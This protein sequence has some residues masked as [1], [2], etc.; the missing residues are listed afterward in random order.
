MCPYSF[1]NDKEDYFPYLYC[2][3]DGKRC[4]YSKKCN[5]EQRYIPL[6]NQEEC[7]KLNE[8]L[9]KS[10]P[11][12]AYFV[13]SARPSINGT[14]LYVEINGS[15][16]KIEIPIKNYDRNFVFIKKKSDGTLMTSDKR[17][18]KYY[19]KKKKN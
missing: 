19:G 14:W 3:L 18:V 5:Q 4:L 7:Y 9:K 10:I 8:E 1:Y 6:D 13:K 17:F 2:K 16:N 15:V 11:E 12:G